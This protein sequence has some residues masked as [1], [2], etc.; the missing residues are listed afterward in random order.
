[1]HDLKP[2]TALWGT[3]AHVDHFEGLTISQLPEWALASLAGRRGQEEA[4]SAAAAGYL[5]APLPETGESVTKG[6]L[7]AFW[8][9]AHQWMIE[10]P[11]DSHEDLASQ[12][13]A[14]VG[15]SGSVTEQND[16]WTR[17][18]LEGPR[19]HDVLERLCNA[20]T[21]MMGQGRV[22][23][24]QLATLGCFLICRARDTHFSVIG[25]RSSARSLLRALTDAARSAI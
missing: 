5:G 11:H 13:K 12:L 8:T 4:C 2:I 14:A 18:D 7:T 21:R 10:A 6:P 15:E 17:F 20:D 24:V 23:R 22:T 3:S 9:G 19:C 25:P 16:G 1:M